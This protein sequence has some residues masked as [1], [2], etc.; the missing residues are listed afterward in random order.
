MFGFL[1]LL[2]KEIQEKLIEKLPLEKE[3]YLCKILGLD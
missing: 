2:A 3:E 1:S